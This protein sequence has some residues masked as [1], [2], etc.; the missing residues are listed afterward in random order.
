MTVMAPWHVISHNLGYPAS[1]ASVE[2][3]FSQVGITFSDKR[4]SGKAATIESIMLTRE[5]I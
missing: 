4:T 1:S 3:P 5:N 2:R